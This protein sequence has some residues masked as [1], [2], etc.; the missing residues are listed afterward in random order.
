MD[1]DSDSDAFESE[2]R[3]HRVPERRRKAPVAKK[4]RID[5]SSSVPPS[6][7]PRRPTQETQRPPEAESE[8]E[9]EESV[10]E[11]E[12]PDM[13]EEIPSSNYQAQRQLAQENQSLNAST[14]R[15]ERKPR[16]GWTPEAEDALCEYMR[17]FPAK[18]SAI[19]KYDESNG[20]FL[21]GRTQVNLKDKVRNM[22]LNMIK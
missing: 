13:T 5:S 2:D 18:Y 9:P 19:L 7:Q 3:G 14:H 22:A 11:T 4:V 17:M 10:S 16:R 15:N 6:Y 8:T 12:A 20:N 1:D 21:Q